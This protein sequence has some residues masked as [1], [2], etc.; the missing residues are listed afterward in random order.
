[1]SAF[2][3]LCAAALAAAA[4]ATTAP[5]SAATLTHAYDFAAAKTVGADS[6]VVDL[7]GGA[8]GLLLNGATVSGGLLSLDGLDDYVQFGT[9]IVATG[10]PFSVFARIEFQ[11]NVSGITEIISQGNSGGPGFYFGENGGGGFR[12][13]D[14]TGGAPPVPAVGGFHALLFTYNAGIVTFS[15]DNGTPT[16][17][18]SS[19]FT[20]GGTDTRL[21]RQF[22]PFNEFFHGEYDSLRTFTGVATYAEATAPLAG[23]SAA[24]EPAAW[25]LMT[26]GFGCA[27]AILRRR[28]DE[29]LAARVGA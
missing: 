26:I 12:L 14:A 21:G 5:A 11:P 23:R 20:T 24:P 27:G 22:S 17:V 8:D 2:R 29:G 18:G 13:G 7:V 25:S 9:K 3:R 28:R 16:V 4:A 15:I 19:G 1:M 6:Y 10:G